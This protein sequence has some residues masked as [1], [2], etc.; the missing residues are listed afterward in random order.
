MHK[1]LGFMGR[2][3]C[4]PLQHQRQP[5]VR[6]HWQG[7]Q[8][9]W[10]LSDSG[11]S[12]STHRQ[13]LNMLPRAVIVQE[14]LDICYAKYCRTGIGIYIESLQLP[15]FCKCRLECGISDVMTV[16]VAATALR[17][18]RCQQNWSGMSS[19]CSAMLSVHQ[20]PAN[21]QQS[22]RH[23]MLCLQGVLSCCVSIAGKRKQ[24]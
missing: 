19:R 17:Q 3:W 15:L 12:G 9:Q 4:V 2:Y 11:S 24:Q 23:G 21:V 7:A 18:C 20:D 1:V 14:Q 8:I 13:D 10:N 16:S 22:L 5:M 6:Q